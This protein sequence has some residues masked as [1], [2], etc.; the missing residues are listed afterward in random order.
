MSLERI[1]TNSHFEQKVGHCRAI[2]AGPHIFVSGTSSMDEN[3]HIYALG[4]PFNQATRALEIILGSLKQFNAGVEHIILIRSY[5]SDRS[6]APEFFRAFSKFFTEHHPAFTMV[7]VS[8]L[9]EEE[10]LIEIE[11]Q[12]YL[13]K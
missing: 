12:A 5:I 8:A 6:Y 11:A 13:E 9:M 1:Y 4:N 2:K 10:M 3:G 7:E